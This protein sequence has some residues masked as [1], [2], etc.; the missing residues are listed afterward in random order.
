MSELT[1]RVDPQR[2][3][4]KHRHFQQKTFMTQAPH[5]PRV[6][7]AFTMVCR[8]LKAMGACL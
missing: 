8:I 4:A 3:H 1:P 6:P 7:E 5:V 2:L